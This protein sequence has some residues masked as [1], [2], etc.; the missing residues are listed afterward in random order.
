MLTTSWRCLQDDRRVTLRGG[1]EGHVVQR[2]LGRMSV[3]FP[4]TLEV[5]SNELSMWTR[6]TDTGNLMYIS[7]LFVG[8]Q[9][10]IVQ[11]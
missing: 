4:V 11:N 9:E 1:G 5:L 3:S 2:V 7:I 6:R 10:Q 8:S